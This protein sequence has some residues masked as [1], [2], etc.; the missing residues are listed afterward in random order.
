[1]AYEGEIR[2][3]LPLFINQDS[4]DVT[5]DVTISYQAC[6]DSECFPPASLRLSLLVLAQENVAG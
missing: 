4:G 5:L 1:M 3:E 6:T 2:G